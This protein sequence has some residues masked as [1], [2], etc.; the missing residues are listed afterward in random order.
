M[1]TKIKLR[2]DI[3]YKMYSLLSPSSSLKIGKK[4]FEVLIL[5]Q[6]VMSVLQN[7]QKVKT[8]ICLMILVRFLTVKSLKSYNEYRKLAIGSL[9][10]STFKPICNIQFISNPFN[11]GSI[12]ISYLPFKGVLFKGF[13]CCFSETLIIGKNLEKSGMK[14]LI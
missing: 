4:W 13:K 11:V 8:F 10:C 3:M 12:I 2:I 5:Y 6:V 9:F 14:L 7:C 1:Y